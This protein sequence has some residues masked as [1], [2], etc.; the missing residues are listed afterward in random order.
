MPRK[1]IDYSKSCIYKI[2]CKDPSITDI[3]IGSTTDLVKRRYS[4]NQVC[5]NPKA[6]SHNSPIYKFIRENGGF[7]N[8]EVV[9]IE[10][11]DCDCSEDLCKR[12]REIFDELKPTLNHN[13]PITS[14]EEKKEQDV[15][16]SKEWY[17][18]NKEYF[19]EYFKYY[20]KIN[21]KHMLEKHEEWRE[22]NK[23]YMKNYYEKN[24]EKSNQKYDCP[25]GGR[26]THQNKPIH[27]KS[28]KHIAWQDKQ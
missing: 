15:K 21:K 4:H 12:E 27:F 16:N 6:T 9:K 11:Y 23:E 17:E 26:Y 10:N 20:F 24:K 19:K 5:K 8:W 25:C 28:K 18:N 7:D 13:R 2:C 1:T 14:V 3:Y 22:N